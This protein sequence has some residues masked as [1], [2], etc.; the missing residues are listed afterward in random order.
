MF[1]PASVSGFR[2]VNA[3]RPPPDPCIRRPLPRMAGQGVE[4]DGLEGAVADEQRHS[5]TPFSDQRT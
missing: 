3:P 2:I 5:D 4:P 1:P